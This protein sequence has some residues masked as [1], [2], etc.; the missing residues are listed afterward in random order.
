MNQLVVNYNTAGYL[1]TDYN[2]IVN[3]FRN[4]S[5]KAEVDSLNKWN[6]KIAWK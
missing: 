5:C 3:L 6:N 2:V 4:N 1:S